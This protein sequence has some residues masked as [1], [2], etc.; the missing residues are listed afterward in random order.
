MRRASVT[1]PA[2][3]FLV[4]TAVLSRFEGNIWRDAG[5]PHHR[6]D[7][8]ALHLQRDAGAPP[9]RRDTEAPPPWKDTGA[10]PLWRGTGARGSSPLGSGSDYRLTANVSC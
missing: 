8:V 6:R 10:P 7:A 9:F 5:A 2:G 3:V 1:T 4:R